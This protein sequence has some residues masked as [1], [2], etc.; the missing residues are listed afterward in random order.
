MRRQQ[1]PI[2]LVLALLEMEAIS[3]EFIV[4]TV[5]AASLARANR[6]AAL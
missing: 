1:S 2:H 4:V 5:S 3:N 6:L